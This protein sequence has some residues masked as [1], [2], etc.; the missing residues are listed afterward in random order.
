[1]PCR[2]IGGLE[3][4]PITTKQMVTGNNIEG[5]EISYQLK[6][7]PSSHHLTKRCTASLDTH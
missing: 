5:L 2:N 4:M 3:T 1:M 6:N 7:T